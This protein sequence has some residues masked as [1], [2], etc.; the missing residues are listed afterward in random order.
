M[1]FIWKLLCTVCLPQA[2]C[3]FVALEAFPCPLY[4]HEDG[5]HLRISLLSLVLKPFFFYD[6]FVGVM[7]AVGQIWVEGQCH[8]KDK[9]M[10]CPEVP[11]SYFI[12]RKK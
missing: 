6:E 1:S 10:C 12:I 11:C 7:A 3:G 9:R 5:I 8:N 2:L 4:G